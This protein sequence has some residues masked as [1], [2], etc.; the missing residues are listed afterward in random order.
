M[1]FLHADVYILPQTWSILPIIMAI[2]L[3]LKSK[4]SNNI[5]YSPPKAGQKS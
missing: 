2:I 4:V 1:S 5:R 3:I